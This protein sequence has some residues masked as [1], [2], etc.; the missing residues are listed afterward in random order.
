MKDHA[1]ARPLALHVA[2][3]DRDPVHEGAP[4]HKVSDSQTEKL[5]DPQSG[6]ES[7]SEQA[8][9]SACPFRAQVDEEGRNF[10]VGEWSGTFHWTS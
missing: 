8:L 4:L 1:T 7:Q 5:A 3:L 2:A 10:L 9:F 6:R